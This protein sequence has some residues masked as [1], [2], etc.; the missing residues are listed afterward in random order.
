MNTNPNTSETFNFAVYTTYS[1]NVAQNSPP[2]GT[3][4]VNLS[5]AP[6]PPIFSASAGA[7]ASSTLTIPRFIS[8]ASAARNFAVIQICRTILL[9]R[10]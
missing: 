7:A 3:S 8:D 2:P 5:F 4:T 1:A 9:F 6:T 10:T